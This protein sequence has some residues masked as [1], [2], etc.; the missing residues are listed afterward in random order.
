MKDEI[1]DLAK[2]LDIS[3]K[4]VNVNTNYLM[5]HLE[6][7]TDIVIPVVCI[8]LIIMI[9]SALVIY[10]IFNM[11]AIQKIRE[12]GRLKAIGANKK[13]LKSIIRFEG[14]ILSFVSI[15]TGILFGSL[16]LK[17]WLTISMHMAI[18][19]FSLP[20]TFLVALLT[21][22]T[23]AVSMHKPIRLAAKASPVEAMRYEAGGKE[24]LRKG[25]TEIRIFSL[26]LSNLSLHKKRTIT[27][28]L[29]MGLSCVLFVIIANIVGNMNAEPQ[30][31]EDRK[32]VV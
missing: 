11:A 19:V 22:F 20:L 27:T 10:N 21:A 29:T 32:S 16:L 4:Q 25:K 1:Y 14:L 24:N 15:P 12:Y 23:V 30:V 26:T 31:R 18:S 8:I 2:D 28:I 6:P 7:S 3:E 17:L 13:Q 9:V 5:W